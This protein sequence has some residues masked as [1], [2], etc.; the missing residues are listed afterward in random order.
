[1]VATGRSFLGAYG[2]AR[3]YEEAREAL[4]LAERFDLDSK[5]DL[6]TCSY[7]RA[8]SGPSG[9]HRPH[10]RHTGTT[11]RSARRC[12]IVDR[13]AP[14]PFQTPGMSRPK[15]RD[16]STYRSAPSPIDWQRS[17]N[18]PDTAQPQQRFALHAAV[19]GARLLEM[20]SPPPSQPLKPT[21]RPI[22]AFAAGDRQSSRVRSAVHA[23]C[24][25]S[26][27]RPPW[28]QQFPRVPAA[29]C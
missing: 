21:A 16:C 20:A 29:P 1:M 26:I 2:I 15:P 14:R 8:G 4:T 17:R 13:H 7:P 19:L 24:T 6:Q 11:Q 27:K 25:T 28:K 3:S 23:P 9:D 22:A 12:H 10:R 5:V 18:S